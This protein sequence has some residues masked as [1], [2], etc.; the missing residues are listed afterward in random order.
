MVFH[1]SPTKKH[2][3]ETTYRS[4]FSPRLLHN[5]LQRPILRPPSGIRKIFCRP[6]V[7][8]WAARRKAPKYLEFLHHPKKKGGGG[9]RA[10]SNEWTPCR[11]VCTLSQTQNNYRFSFDLLDFFS[12]VLI[13]LDDPLFSPPV[14]FWGFRGGFP[15]LAFPKNAMIGVW[16]L[17]DDHQTSEFL[18][19]KAPI[20]RL[21][22]RNKTTTC[23]AT[24]AN[25]AVFVF[26]KEKTQKMEK[27]GPHFLERG[28]T[29]KH[30]FRHIRLQ[31][32]I[33]QE[34]IG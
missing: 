7:F 8:A 4:T 6:K 16:A 25:P 12:G 14:C 22:K 34:S 27:T 31:T 33:F 24:M 9:G 26:L 1:I 2:R 15:W 19:W 32:M 11:S 17:R 20:C 29:A 3:F 18:L 28:S 21:A 30:E 10:R 13:S 5:P 23:L